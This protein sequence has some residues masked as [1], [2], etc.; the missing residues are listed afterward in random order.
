DLIPIEVADYLKSLS[1]QG[2][3]IL[4]ITGRTLARTRRMLGAFKFTYHI[5]VQ[6]GAQIFEMPSEKRIVK[7]FLPEGALPEIVALT[8]DDPMGVVLYAGDIQKDICYY[9]PADFSEELMDYVLRRAETFGEE[10]K[11]VD[12]ILRF[13]SA[14]FP[15]LKL[16]GPYPELERV[17]R[18]SRLDIPVIR[19]PFGKGMF[20]AQGTAPGTNK[21]S[22][23]EN[24]QRWL[25]GHQKTIVAGDDRNDLPMLAKADVKVVM[26]TAPREVLL[27]ADIVAPPA[28]ELGIIEGL[29]KAIGLTK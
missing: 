15:A 13:E 7:R 2:W 27:V 16:I 19:D 26:A 21:G 24:F 3:E 10:W 18:K 22:A 1:G 12:D 14:D 6:N 29:E 25:D 5:A 8:L 9:C 4:F 17:C 28:A 23:L 20:V 11:A